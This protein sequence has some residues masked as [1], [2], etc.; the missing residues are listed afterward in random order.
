MNSN[1]RSCICAPRSVLKKF[2]C[3]I[4]CTH[5]TKN[6]E[7]LIYFLN[8]QIWTSFIPKTAKFSRSCSLQQASSAR[9]EVRVSV[10]GTPFPVNRPSFS[11]RVARLAE[12][13]M[14]N[15]SAWVFMRH[16]LHT[17]GKTAGFF[18]LKSASVAVLGWMVSEKII[19]KIYRWQIAVHS[20]RVIAKL[21]GT[22]HHKVGKQ[23]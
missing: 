17:S 9:V 8:F 21:Q 1:T 22:A 19:L 23:L 3:I 20:C 4:L 2:L 11:W 12:P 16:Q 7:V 10:G 18:F 15:E 6:R 13:L 14:S 5:D